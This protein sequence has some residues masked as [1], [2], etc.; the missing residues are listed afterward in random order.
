MP[1]IDTQLYA[2]AKA[3]VYKKYPTHSAYR[4]GLLVQYYKKLG[5]RYSGTKPSK[6]GLARWFKEDWKSDRG[7]Y[8]YTSKSS[9]YRP[10]RRITS[11]TPITFSELSTTELKRAKREKAR[12]GHVRR[13]SHLQGQ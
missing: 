2:R 8:G 10:T 4:S 9:V 6:V 11:K 1:P 7:K 12:T 5:G 3:I 13:F